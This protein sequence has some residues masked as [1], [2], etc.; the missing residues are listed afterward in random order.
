MRSG[1]RSEGTIAQFRW[2]Y[3]VFECY[4]LW[5]DA[6]FLHIAYNTRHSDI[7]PWR[8]FE[9]MPTQGVL[10]PNKRSRKRKAADCWGRL[11]FYTWQGYA[12]LSHICRFGSIKITSPALSISTRTCNKFLPHF[13]I[14][15]QIATRGNLVH[16]VLSNDRQSRSSSRFFPLSASDVEL[17]RERRMV[18][19]LFIMLIFANNAK[20]NWTHV[21]LSWVLTF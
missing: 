16:C 6:M 5:L 19:L 7:Y 21:F 10:S 11:T 1:T 3:L 20:E 12:W 9:G 8:Y 13:L 2:L 4:S 18:F 17:Q 14:Y 15:R